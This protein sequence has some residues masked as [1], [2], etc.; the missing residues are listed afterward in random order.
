MKHAEAHFE[1]PDNGSSNL[2]K[3]DYVG[4]F[5]TFQNISPGRIKTDQGNN[6]ISVIG[7]ADV[8]FKSV[9]V[10]LRNFAAK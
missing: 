7:L 4:E 3:A 6:Q 9:K 5:Y 10:A 8:L 1:R 2:S